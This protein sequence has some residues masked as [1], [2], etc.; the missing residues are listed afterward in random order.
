MAE[1]LDYQAMLLRNNTILLLL[2]KKQNTGMAVT[3]RGCSAP[4]S[5]LAAR[6][7]KL[8]LVIPG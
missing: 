4:S 2:Q 6:G 5:R 7:A 3:L 8:V 1:L